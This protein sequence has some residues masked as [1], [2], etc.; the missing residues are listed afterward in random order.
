MI[1]WDLSASTKSTYFPGSL[2]KGVIRAADRFETSIREAISPDGRTAAL[3][4][5]DAQV[6]IVDFETGRLLKIL[7]WPA[8]SAISFSPDGRFL[9][10]ANQEA[11]HV[12]D[13]DGVS[14]ISINK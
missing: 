5:K 14:N 11:V 13:L 4:W 9:A 12:W 8:K 10:F 6:A 2:S 7:R 3:K 1:S